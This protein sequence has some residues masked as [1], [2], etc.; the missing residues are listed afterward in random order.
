LIILFYYNSFAES[1]KGSGRF[2]LGTYPRNKR[3]LARAVRRIVV[4]QPDEKI[5]ETHTVRNRPVMVLD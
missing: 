4:F 2:Y 3:K 1:C 5:E